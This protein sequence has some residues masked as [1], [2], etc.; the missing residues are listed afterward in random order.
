MDSTELQAELD[1]VYAR[2][3]TNNL[4]EE[5]ELFEKVKKV[6]L[7]RQMEGI[8][9]DGFDLACEEDVVWYCWSNSTDCAKILD[10]MES[11]NEAFTQLGL[12]VLFSS[13]VIETL[14]YITQ[15]KK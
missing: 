11:H 4:P 8:F 6:Y 1:L 7:D 13:D 15:Y 12:K 9:D 14:R 3:L 5:I 2:I 10:F